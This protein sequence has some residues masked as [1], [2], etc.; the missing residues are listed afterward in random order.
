VS[1]AAPADKELVARVRL[2]DRDAYGVLVQR[3]QHPLYR[4]CRGMG[5]DHDTAL[6][7]VQ[8]SFIRGYTRLADCR[9]ATHF[10]AWLFRIL[11]N[12]CLDHLKNL[13]NLTVSLNDVSDA[14][15]GSRRAAP[16]NELGSTL[17]DALHRL[18]VALREAFLLKHDAGYSY[19]EIAGMTGATTSAVKMR[20]HRARE[21]LRE[22]LKDRAVA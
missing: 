22:M 10:R 2:G 7:L 6:D 20:V 17:Q 14:D 13:R 1:S 21:T 4:Y 3:H 15:L 19:E 12:R 5:F 11:R 9:D 16:A 8:D 18:P